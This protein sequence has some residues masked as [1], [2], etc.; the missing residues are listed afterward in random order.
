MSK[1]VPELEALVQKLSVTVF[2]QNG[3]LNEAQAELD[4]VREALR[5]SRLSVKELH[6]AR[7][8]ARA[9]SAGVIGFQV[10][11]AEKNY[12]PE[13]FGSDDVFGYDA[14]MYIRSKEKESS[15]L[16]V[17]IEEGDIDSPRL[18]HIEDLV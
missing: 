6:K 7:D 1:T 18:F 4:E 3:K 14:A 9:L 2:E 11:H 13:G 12:Y 10:R 8:V 15:W 17:P 5:V 16:L